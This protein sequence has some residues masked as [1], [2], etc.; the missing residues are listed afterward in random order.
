MMLR[1]ILITINQKQLKSANMSLRHMMVL[2]GAK[3]GLSN[4]MLLKDRLYFSLCVF[5]S[6]GLSE[7]GVARRRGAL[8]DVKLVIIPFSSNH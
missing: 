5:L 2:I 6:D 8:F 4:S 7:R 3:K 1:S